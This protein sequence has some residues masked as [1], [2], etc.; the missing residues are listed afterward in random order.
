MEE[1]TKKAFDFTTEAI[2]QLIALSTGVL[3]ITITFAKDVSGLGHAAPPF[4]LMGAWLMYLVSIV[5]GVATMFSLVATLEPKSGSNAIVIGGNLVETG[6]RPNLW[7]ESITF[8]S[9]LQ[10]LFFILGTL[11]IV[12]Y[13]IWS[14]WPTS[15]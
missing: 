4:V 2:K 15:G 7:D 8:K 10:I 6:Y 14:L 1:R 13:G 3:A 12:I 5:F 9:K 11:G